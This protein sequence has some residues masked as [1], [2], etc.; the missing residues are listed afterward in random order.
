MLIWELTYGHCVYMLGNKCACLNNNR[1]KG[2]DLTSIQKIMQ[3]ATCCG[4]VGVCSV[5]VF[6]HCVTGFV[7]NHMPCFVKKFFFLKKASPR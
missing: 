3:K 2:E 7:F 1:N 4:F 6:S 5:I